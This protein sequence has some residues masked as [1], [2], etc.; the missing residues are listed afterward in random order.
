MLAKLE[1]GAQH[2]EIYDAEY[3]AT[4]VEPSMSASAG[5]MAHAIVAE[6]SPKTIVDVG[7]GTGGLM[8]ALTKLGV[9]CVG[10]DYSRAAV[11]LC[12][13]RGL[14]VRQFDLESG[15]GCDLRADVVISTEV[16]EHLPASCADAYVALL[17]GIAPSIVFTAAP[18]S[19]HAGT[20]HVNEQ[21]N[22]YWIERFAALGRRHRGE[23][24]ARWRHDWEAQGVSG[25]YSRSVMVFEN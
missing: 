17:C 21:P 22:E 8:L 4:F 3:Y 24:S 23:L 5:V 7:C 25:I 1:Q 14:D 18:P 13:G 19:G 15:M 16:A 9:R 20:D 12:V 11:E 2:D 10:L 6:F